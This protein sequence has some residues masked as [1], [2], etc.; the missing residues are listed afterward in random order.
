MLT[1]NFGVCG[2]KEDT[3]SQVAGW[4]GDKGAEV[5]SADIC[6]EMDRRPGLTFLKYKYPGNIS[7]P[8]FVS[9]S[10]VCYGDD[11]IVKMAIFSLREDERNCIKVLYF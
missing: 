7:Q 4:W 5:M 10:F 8:D 3:P 1:D 6:R 2:L 11:G 9:C